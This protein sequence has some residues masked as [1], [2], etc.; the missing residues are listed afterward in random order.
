MKGEKLLELKKISK[1]FGGLRA[2]ND[3]NIDVQGG[4]ITALIGPNGA[5]KSTI[6]NLITGV[7]RPSQGEIHFDGTKICGLPRHKI[8]EKG[9][10]RTFQLTKMFKGMTVLENVMVGGHHWARHSTFLPVILNRK[11]VR[12]EEEEIHHYALEM[13]R[14]VGLEKVAHESAGNLPHGQQRLLEVAR[15]MATRP[16]LILLD[17]PAA[18]LNGSEEDMLR[19]ALRAIVANGTTIFMVEHHMKLVMSVSDNVHVM[20][21][22]T[23]IAEGPPAEIGKNPAVV[24]AYLGKEY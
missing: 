5:G 10:A 21:V 17:E 19:D 2:L 11:A 4:T 6:I 7:H 8:V 1:F 13:L 12:K 23:K 18:G 20:D 22:G 3:I 9:L 14:L 24:K 16:K 15:S